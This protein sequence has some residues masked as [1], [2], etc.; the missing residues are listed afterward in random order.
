[1][2]KTTLTISGIVFMLAASG[3]SDP[4]NSIDAAALLEDRCGSCHSSSIPKNARKSKR[5]WAETVN[6]M[7]ARGAKLSPEERK[8]L[9]K[10]LAEIYRP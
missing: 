5:D 3:C 4:K 10:H 8:V 1:M 6:R 7:I 9:I 2:N